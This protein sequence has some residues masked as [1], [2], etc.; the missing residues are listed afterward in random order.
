MTAWEKTKKAKAQFELKMSSVVSDNKKGFFKY[1]N[2]KRRS[3]ENIGPILVEDGHLT[4]RN[5]EKVEAFSA[6]FASVFNNTDR[7]WA[8]Q[9]PESEDRECGNS[10]FPFVDAENHPSGQVVQLWDEQVH[11]ALGEKLAQSVVANGATSGWQLITSS[12]PQ[13]SILGPVMFNIFIDNL[14]AGVEC[15]ITS[16]LMIP[17]CEV[18]LTL[19]RDKADTLQRDLDR[20]EH[21]AM[22]NGMKFNKLKCQILHLGQSNSGHKYKLGEEWLESSP[23][24]RDLGVL[25]DSR[26]NMSQQCV[27]AAKRTNFILGCIKHSITSW[28][29]KVI[30][31][32]YS[33]L[34]QPH[35]EFWAPHFKKDVK[36]L[37]WIQRRAIKLVKGLEEMSY[38]K[39]LGTLSFSGLE[40]RRL[41]AKLITLYSFLRRASGEG[42]A[43]LFSL[44]SSDRTHGNGSKLCQGRFR[45]DIRIIE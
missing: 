18:L 17:N 24:E 16:L 31:L 14:D 26:L 25:A 29:N 3:K 6:I 37:E 2:S 23:A 10:G 27:R 20:L 28:S 45:P 7:P 9:F 12:V 4:N 41:K 13:G 22:I 32:L 44:V 8:A 35:L 5:E 39:E 21:W 43:E 1:V 40:K 19:S 36:V 38:E 34:V 42:G 30:I 15:T 11:G 33:A